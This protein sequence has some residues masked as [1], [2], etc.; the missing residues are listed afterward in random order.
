MKFA[1]IFVQF[2]KPLLLLADKIIA[3]FGKGE[4]L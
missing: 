3:V 2:V 1:A 4:I